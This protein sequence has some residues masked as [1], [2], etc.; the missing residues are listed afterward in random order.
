MKISSKLIKFNKFNKSNILGILFVVLLCIS[1]V[2]FNLYTRNENVKEGFTWSQDTINNFVQTQ[3][4]K[5]PQVLFDTDMLQQQVNEE[6]ATDF[7]KNG[8]W[9]WSDKVKNLYK[10]A[11][12]K[13]PYVQTYPEDSMT[14]ARKIYNEKSILDI[15]SQQTKEGQF[16]MNGIEVNTETDD[17]LKSGEGT[18]GY[19]SGLITPL[20]NKNSKLILCDTD[21]NGQSILK[22]RQFIKDGGILGEHV[23]KITTPDY[24]DL[25]SIIP[26]FQFINGPCNPC[27]NLNN[28]NTN[29]ACPFELNIQNSPSGTSSVWKYIWNLSNDEI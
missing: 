21:K 16:L 19:T 20:V 15:L 24:H 9:S 7:L 28:A 3:Q 22:Q 8:S 5:T 12:A 29:N 25:E 27:S 2:F 18:F 23:Y 10:E 17:I 1:I 6:D 14:D 4:T 26:G 11:S 13:N